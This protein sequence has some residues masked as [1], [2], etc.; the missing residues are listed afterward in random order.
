[1]T[2]DLWKNINSN[3]AS[4]VKINYYREFTI[5]KMDEKDPSTTLNT[6]CDILNELGVKYWVSQGTLLGFHRDKNFITGDSDLDIE[7]MGG[8]QKYEV[9]SYFLK[10]L[11]EYDQEL[12]KFKTRKKQKNGVAYGYAKLCGAADYRQPIAVTTEELNRINESEE[13]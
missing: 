9:K 11:K 5:D 6:G 13:D 8:E 2:I 12:F 3:W 7:Q 4:D 1:M 10:R